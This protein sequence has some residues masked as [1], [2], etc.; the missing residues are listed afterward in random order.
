MNLTKKENSRKKTPTGQLQTLHYAL[1]VL[2]LLSKQSS[3]MRLTDIG[4]SLGLAK[5]KVFRVLATLAERGYVRKDPRNHDYSLDIGVWGLARTVSDIS[6]LA[7]F[8][9][10]FVDALC[11]TAQE[12]AFLSILH[13]NSIMYLYTK[14]GPSPSLYLGVGSFLPCHAT[15]SGKALLAQQ[16]REFINEYFHDNLEKLTESTLTNRNSLI[17]EL[18]IIRQRGYSIERDEWGVGFSGVA[19]VIPTVGKEKYAAIGLFYPT[20]RAEDRKL[21]EFIDLLLDTQR[22]IIDRH[23][24]SERLSEVII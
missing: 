23:P 21:Q 20:G 1:D 19:T 5:S 7:D 8:A 17:K 2:E 3:P 11:D 12:T 24:T 15:A 4:K 9:K 13:K 6:Q 10:P 22:K 16:S 18:E 14:T